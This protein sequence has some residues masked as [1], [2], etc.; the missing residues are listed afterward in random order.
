M[1]P[2]ELTQRS[3]VALPQRKP[4]AYTIAQELGL[5]AW[6]RRGLVEALSEGP[7]ALVV[8]NSGGWTLVFGPVGGP[9][10]RLFTGASSDESRCLFS[11]D[12]ARAR[13][14]SAR[15]VGGE[16]V[17]SVEGHDG[18]VSQ[19]GPPG[20]RREPAQLRADAQTV[21]DL[22]RAWGCDPREA[23]TSSERAYVLRKERWYTHAAPASAEGSW[24]EAVVVAL[25]IVAVLAIIVWCAG[26][27]L[28]DPP[29]PAQGVGGISGWVE[30][31]EPLVFQEVC[32]H[33]GST[34]R[35]C[36]GCAF[37]GPCLGALSACLEQP[38]CLRMQSCFQDCSDPMAELQR[39]GRAVLFGD[40]EPCRRTC[41]EQHP[42]G[43]ALYWAL[44]SCTLCACASLCR[45][46][47]YHD[48][49]CDPEEARGW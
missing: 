27:M 34:C 38:G 11:I 21:L 14:R 42:E 23:L 39:T 6:F 26:G 31:P 16:L 8:V 4:H 3:W 18:Q 35:E 46:A 30:P 22:A 15:V 28:Q 36:S 10:E 2:S 24:W 43:A 47:V 7:D 41:A 40:P 49:V 9:H 32:E 20:R 25:A 13:Y 48:C 33:E 19:L 17:R 1:V 37:G 29:R 12:E 45:E 5:R 44:R